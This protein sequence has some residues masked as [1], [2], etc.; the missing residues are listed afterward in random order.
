[1]I[2]KS[3]RQPSPEEGRKRHEN[4]CY[5]YRCISFD[6]DS[7]YFYYYMGNRFPSQ[8]ERRT[9]ARRRS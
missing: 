9:K 2:Y 8:Q 5:N 7:C 6:C 3:F 1:M 4:Y